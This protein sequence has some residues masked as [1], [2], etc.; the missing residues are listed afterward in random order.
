MF[1]LTSF[2]TRIGF[3]VIGVI[4]C[5]ILQ[6]LDLFHVGTNAP[7]HIFPSLIFIPPLALFLF[8]SLRLKIF[9]FIFISIGLM[10]VFSMSHD[11]VSFYKSKEKFEYNKYLGRYI[12][13]NGKDIKGEIII[14]HTGRFS[15]EVKGYNEFILDSGEG[16]L[17]GNKLLF[18]DN[19]SEV[20]L[21]GSIYGD[22]IRV[23]LWTVL[24]GDTYST[25]YKLK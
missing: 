7:D 1:K 3:Y 8:N 23:H 14:M 12:Y 20:K 25:Y 4:I 6:A 22:L 2:L 9:F 15:Y 16:I 5:F 21:S 24:Y 19:N 13:D 17:E 18:Y 10:V 11:G